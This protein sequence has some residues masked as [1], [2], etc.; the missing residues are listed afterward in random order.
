MATKFITESLMLKMASN[1]EIKKLLPCFNYINQ[2][3]K[4]SCCRRANTQLLEG[5]NTVRSC[6][7]DAPAEVKRELK[8]ILGVDAKDYLRIRIVRNG[9]VVDLNF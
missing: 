8:K 4:K 2:P 7:A 1:P 3:V 6:I 5:F 9:K